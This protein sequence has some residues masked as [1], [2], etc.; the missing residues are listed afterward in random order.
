LGTIPFEPLHPDLEALLPDFDAWVRGGKTPSDAAL[1]A[2]KFGLSVEQCEQLKREYLRRNQRFIDY[3]DPRVLLENPRIES[4][5]SG[6]DQAGAWCWPA[7]W[8]ML[9]DPSRGWDPDDLGSLNRASTKILASLPH[10][11]TW[12]FNHRGLV[13]GYVQSGKTANYSALIA[14]AADV[15]YRLFIVLSGVTS[16]LRQQTQKRLNADIVAHAPNNWSWLTYPERDFHGSPAGPDAVIDVQSHRKR[17]IAVVKK[18]VR[19][20][21]RLIEWLGAASPDTVRNCPVIVIDDEADNA[22]VNTKDKDVDPTRVNSRIRLLLSS[23]KK[24]AYVGYTATPFA[25]IFINPRVPDDLF[26]R[27]FI[28]DLDRPKAYFGAERLFGREVLRVDTHD[29]DVDGLDVVRTVVVPTAA[30][31]DAPNEPAMLMP[32]RAQDR[33]AFEPALPT[34]LVQAIR[35]FLLATAARFARGHDDKHSSMLVHTTM[36][37]V[38]HD[39]TQK[40]LEERVR[41]IKAHLHLSRD[42]FEALWNEETGKVSPAGGAQTSFDLLW[43]RLPDVIDRVEV[44][45][46]NGR[47]ESTLKYEEGSP[48]VVIA[49]GGNTFSRGLTLEGLVVSYF[50]RRAAAYDTLLQMGRWFGYRPGYEDLPRI[51]MTDELAEQFFFLA[52]IEEE[53]RQDIR[54]LEREQKTPMDLAIRVRTHPKLMITARNKRANARLASASYSNRTLQSFLFNHLDEPWLDQNLGQARKLGSE[55]RASVR[56]AG[57][58][59]YVTE[60]VGVEAVLS[61]L[62]GYRFHEDH[63]ELRIGLL[64][65]YIAAEN[66]HGSLRQW[67]V[68]WIGQAVEQEGLG[69]LDMGLGFSLNC[70]R[71]SR[72][73]MKQPCNIKALISKS[74][75]VVDLAGVPADA[76]DA[77][78]VSARNELAPGVGLLLLYPVSRNSTPE[79]KNGWGLSFCSACGRE[80]LRPIDR[81]PVRHPLD[82]VRDIV[83]AALVFPQAEVEDSSYMAVDLPTLFLPEEAEEGEVVPDETL[84]VEG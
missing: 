24:V 67:N 56:P 28:F 12:P 79:A 38:L 55:V 51:W 50:T 72:F 84:D 11:G 57:P 20:L 65:R 22:S 19:I 26:P 60:G 29:E 9:T 76:T 14:K 81:A 78:I 64:E 1:S 77:E 27:H 41:Q 4:W 40:L 7:Y 18:N 83:G 43:T 53:V 21:D 30:K 32:A 33:F 2:R 73:S 3:K 71:R 70:I 35:Y 17:V 58:G 68:G 63:D 80:H 15:G 69:H 52:G 37:V 46:D 25:N 48:R 39:K 16:N 23:V 45:V 8:R 54:R 75:R 5:Y 36:Y 74:D 13:V 31:A 49:V 42:E 34:S 61:F 6:P 59:R 82:A 44:V 66:A 62:R 10:P 47:T